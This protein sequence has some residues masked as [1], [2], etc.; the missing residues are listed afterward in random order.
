MRAAAAGVVVKQHHFVGSAGRLE[1]ARV[2]DGAAAARRYQQRIARRAAGSHNHL[3]AQPGYREA[4][5]GGMGGAVVV[6]VITSAALE[7]EREQL[8]AAGVLEGKANLQAG[9]YV[10]AIVHVNLEDLAA[11][12]GGG[13]RAGQ[14]LASGAAVKTPGLA[15][16]RV[17]IAVRVET[18]AV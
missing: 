11:G 5:A 7:I 8:G 10:G 4:D 18:I 3:N 14:V 2:F 9:V 13:E 1:G 16:R 6:N 12:Q 17:D 15:T